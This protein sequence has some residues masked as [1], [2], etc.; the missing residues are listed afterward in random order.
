MKK[1]SIAK[2]L[3]IILLLAIVCGCCAMFVAC[4]KEKMP[5]ITDIFKRVNSAQEFSTFEQEFTL[6]TGWSVYTSSL[7]ST[8]SQKSSANLNS[9]IG[10]IPSVNAFV[11]GD[12]DMDVKTDKNLSIVKCDDERVYFEGGMKGMILPNYIGIRALRVKDGL[13]ACKFSNGEA[14]VFDMNGNTVLSRTKV[15]QG[16]KAIPEKTIIDNAIKILD[17]GLIAVNGLYDVNGVSGYTSI[18]RPTNSGDLSTRGELVARVANNDNKLSYVLGFDSKYVTVVG[19]ASGDCIYAIPNSANGNPRNMS[20]T[21][22]GTVVD[23]GQDDYFSEITYMGNGKFFI[24]E[25]WTVKESD[26]YT[27]YDGYDYYSVRRRVYQPD[28][29]KSSDYTANGDKIFI[30][31]GNNY[32]GTEKAGIDTSS[33]LNNGFTY[34]SYGLTIINKVGFYDQFILDQNFN[35]VMSL[36]GNYGITIKDQKKEKVGYFDLIMQ[37]VD[38]YFY[39]PIL[40]SQLNV[41]DSNGNLVGHGSGRKVL[42]QELSNNMIVAS[43]QDPD[44][45]D[46]TLYGAFN[47]YGEEVVP[48]EYLSLSAFRGSYTIGQKSV[49]NADGVRRKEMFIVGSDGKTINEMTDGSKPLSDMA[50]DQNGNAIYKIGCY[51]FKVDSGQKNAEGKTIYNYGIKNFNPNVERNVVM[52]AT[53]RSGSVLYAPSNSA[54]DVFVFEKIGDGSNVVYTVYRL[55]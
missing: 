49:E 19:N 22:N 44:D 54:T 15:G 14:G 48:F 43:I 42:Q 17:G 45:E 37:S 27:Y 7:S 1:R 29:D 21:Q 46:K 3:S 12:K 53:M 16:E 51:M 31:L 25:D 23:E 9:D 24:H 34:A 38:G 6:P 18:Y 4:N 2:V 52:P 39:I 32:Y 10:Y 20:G 47:L 28:N 40:P 11:V 30:Y 26:E 5:T 33:Y 50:T 13:I 36:T 55:K 35:V 41:Y 8:D